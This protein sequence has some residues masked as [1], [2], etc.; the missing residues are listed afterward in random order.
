MGGG[1]REEERE[2]E[3]SVGQ[4][5]GGGVSEGGA[6]WLGLWQASPFPIFLFFW[7]LHSPLL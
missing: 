4:E 3:G 1:G 7:V 5:E 2:E 6:G